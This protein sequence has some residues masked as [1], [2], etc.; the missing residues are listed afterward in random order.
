[1]VRKNVNYQ[2]IA[3]ECARKRTFK[4]RKVGLLKKASELQTLCGVETCAILSNSTDS[5][6]E[7]W[8]SPHDAYQVVERFRNLAP[9]KQTYN[10]MDGENLVQKNIAI[11][12]GKLVTEEKKNQG[13][14]IEQLMRKLLIKESL[15][16]VS[17]LVDLKDL[18]LLLDDSIELVEKRVED[19]EHSSSSP[20]ASGNKFVW[21]MILEVIAVKM[22]FESCF[23]GVQFLEVV[24][25]VNTMVFMEDEDVCSF[26]LVSVVESVKEESRGWFATYLSFDGGKVLIGNDVSYKVVGISSISIRMYDGIVRTLTNVRHVPE[27][28]KTLISLGTLDSN[29]CSYRAT[30]GVISI[31]KGALVVMKGLKPNSLY[32]LQGSTVTGAAAAA[33]SSDIDSDTIKLWHMRLGHMSERGMDVLSKQSLLG[34]KKIGKLDFC[35]HCVFGKHCR[36]KFSRVVHTTKRDVT[37][38]ESSMLSKKELIH[39]GKDHGVREK[40]ELEVR[41]PDSLPIIPTD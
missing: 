26:D 6:L 29:G 35:E 7:V 34:S 4:K 27:L 17:T 28:R 20:V 9:E 39:A 37:F 41:A 14:R 40:V 16:D 21:R 10:M 18:N 12:K 30:G 15:D 32:L 8:P 36:I 33:S 5:H 19:L 25:M 24:M 38:D 22:D 2:F 3:D 1:M 31:M 13:L 11:M 23:I